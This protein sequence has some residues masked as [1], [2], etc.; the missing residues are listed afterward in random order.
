M[1]ER[2]LIVLAYVA[3]A[4]PGVLAFAYLTVNDPGITILAG[5]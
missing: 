5:A 1:S 2:T 3:L 4:A